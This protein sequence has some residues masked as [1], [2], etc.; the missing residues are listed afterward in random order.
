MSGFTSTTIGTSTLSYTLSNKPYTDT[1]DVVLSVGPY[2]PGIS[3][4]ISSTFSDPEFPQIQQD[5]TGVAPLP[6]IQASI[7]NN[8]QTGA[9][10]FCSLTFYSDASV[11]L[12]NVNMTV[13]ITTTEPTSVGIY[14]V[15]IPAATATYTNML[16]NGVYN[17]QDPKSPSGNV[18]QTLFYS[19]IPTNN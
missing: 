12:T 6:G 19:K 14:S 2:G 13:N 1:A 15:N 3:F 17:F 11:N 10:T 4:T 9:L 16:A 8:N 7:G 18:Y 5:Y